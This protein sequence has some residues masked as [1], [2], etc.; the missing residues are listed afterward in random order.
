MNT[1]RGP[2]ADAPKVDLPTG[3]VKPRGSQDRLP[4]SRQAPVRTDGSRQDLAQI[5][6]ALNRS[7]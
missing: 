2:D 3:E 4:P 1:S 7:E 6:D 5:T